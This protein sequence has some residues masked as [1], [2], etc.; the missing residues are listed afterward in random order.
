MLPTRPAHV[1][2]VFDAH[3]SS[4][5][6][7]LLR[8][9]GRVQ[10]RLSQV[11]AE[12]ARDMQAL[13]AEVMQ[14]RGQLMVWRTATWWSLPGPLRPQVRGPAQPGRFTPPAATPPDLEQ[15]REVICQTGCVGHAHHWLQSDGRCQWTLQA[16][17][18]L[19]PARASSAA[20][21]F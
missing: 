6:A 11:V 17:E 15:A 16:C 2:L 13:H 19:L 12:Q 14:L 9:L 3:P 8:H 10:S 1:A 18:R 20:A 21:S 7:A 4:E 5:H